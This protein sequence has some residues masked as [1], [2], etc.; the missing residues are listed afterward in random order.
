MNDELLVSYLLGEGDT[1]SRRQVERWINENPANQRYFEHFRIVWDA[2]QRL[3]LPPSINED[4]AWQKFRKRTFGA[5]TKEINTAR[6]WRLPAMFKAAAAVVI[7]IGIIALAYFS[8]RPG[9]PEVIF[10]AADQPATEMLPDGSQV[11]L[12][13]NSS[14]EYKGKRASRQLRLKGE[15]FFNV[16][17]ERRK[18]FVIEVNNITVTV[19]GTAFNVRTTDSTTE[20]AVESGV[21]KVDND[22][23]STLVKAGETL[24]VGAKDAAP[25]PQQTTGRLYNYY[26]TKEFVCDN[27]PLWKLVETL[28]EAYDVNI[29]IENTGI[30]SLPLTTTFHNEPLENILQI[31]SE[32]LDVTVDREVDRI[33]LK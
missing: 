26:V 21:V 32:T 15:A 20:I 9:S 29:V 2:S 10:A 31:I 1:E 6:S 16:T 18:P 30:R 11:T 27:T 5:R 23:S 19:V 14:V 17:A 8:L 33:I 28:N 3:S 22:N 25:A 12:N 13:K 7:G 24:S 4:E